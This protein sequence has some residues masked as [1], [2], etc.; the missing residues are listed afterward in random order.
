MNLSDPLPELHRSCLDG[1]PAKTRR[2]LE[3]GAS[4]NQQDSLDRTALHLAVIKR[5]V[6]L[7]KLLMKYKA[8]PDIPD[9]DFSCPIHYAC[10]IGDLHF[11]SL[12]Y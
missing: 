8:D 9:E 2:L 6:A 11:T 5:N 10:A 3:A 1:Q 7:I 12:K 4:S